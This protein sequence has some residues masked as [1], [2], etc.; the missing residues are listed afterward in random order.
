MSQK[1]KRVDYDYFDFHYNCK[2]GGFSLLDT[3]INDM[4]RGLYLRDIGMY[5]E[6]HTV[7]KSNGKM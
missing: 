6:K 7:Y 2:K 4:I 1:G 5:C 3:Y